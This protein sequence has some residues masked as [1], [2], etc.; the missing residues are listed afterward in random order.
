ML[1]PAWTTATVVAP[2]PV[3]CWVLQ[4]E[5]GNSL[6]IY[7]RFRYMTLQRPLSRLSH[8]RQCWHSG[9]GCKDRHVSWSACLVKLRSAAAVGRP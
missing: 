7:S 3:S 2:L 9:C 4:K 1:R 8:W 5:D 6:Q